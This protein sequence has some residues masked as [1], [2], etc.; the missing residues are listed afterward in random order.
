[1]VFSVFV[2]SAPWETGVLQH[3]IW[4]YLLMYASQVHYGLSVLIAFV[5][6]FH[7]WLGIGR[8]LCML[9]CALPT[10]LPGHLYWLHAILDVFVGCVPYFLSQCAT[11]YIHALLD[12]LVAWVFHYHA[13]CTISS[14][15]CYVQ[16]Y[17]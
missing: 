11:G 15:S 13:Q 1:M 4:V 14:V 16:V 3:S 7:A 8:L 2:L 9:C 6:H 17:L 5:L 12:I 10:Q